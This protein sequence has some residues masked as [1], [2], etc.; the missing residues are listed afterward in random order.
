[1]RYKL[2]RLECLGKC[3][4]GAGCGAKG[5]NWVWVPESNAVKA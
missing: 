2:E 5:G 4:G 3:G 1:M